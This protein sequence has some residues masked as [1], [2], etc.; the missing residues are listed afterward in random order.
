MRDVPSPYSFLKQATKI[1]PQLKWA[2]FLGGILAVPALALAWYRTRDLRVVG[3]SA[4]TMLFFVMV[5]AICAK[6][7]QQSR[8]EFRAPGR[9]FTWFCLIAFMVSACAFFGSIVF[10]TP[11][12]DWSFL[13]NFS[14]PERAP[15]Q[16]VGKEES[17]AN[18]NEETGDKAASRAILDY[19]CLWGK[20]ATED[21]PYCANSRYTNETFIRQEW[22]NAVFYW[23]TAAALSKDEVQRV[24]LSR[25]LGDDSSLRCSADKRP[26]CAAEPKESD[27]FVDQ[28]TREQLIIPRIASWK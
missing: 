18:G 17:E 8:R 3:I 11:Q 25:K 5:A 16:A 1:V 4:F 20:K 9:V 2:W 13:S 12:I 26:I 6:A 19:F 23:Q 7:T 27:V 28:T 10:H 24:R 14:R 22:R 21:R 15:K